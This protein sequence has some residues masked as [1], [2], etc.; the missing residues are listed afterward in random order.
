MG[1]NDE[2]EL[3]ERP[4]HDVTVRSFFLDR[5]EVTHA[6]YETCVTAGRCEPPNRHMASSTHAGAD[7][8]F[9][10]PLQPVVGVRWDDAK[11]YC[12]YVG[13]RLPREAEFERAIRGDDGRRY[14]W[15]NEAPTPEHTVFGRLLGHGGTTDDVGTHAK[16]RGQY[17]HDDLAGNV[18]EWMEDLYD[19]LAYSRPG[20]NTGTPGSCDEIL[21]TLSTLRKEGRRGFTGSNPIPKT[22][23]RVL[24]GGA[25]NY[26]RE[27]LRSTNRVH[28]PGNYRLVMSG[29]RC[30]KDAH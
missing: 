24:R 25:F 9:S 28:H 29:F 10:R 12:A 3:D 2:G 5:A 27:G 8:D 26:Q 30:A 20:A 22:C 18:W 7:Q 23:E 17:G 15:G 19:P 16:G 1:T 11:A 14:P 4:A 6:A 21:E 13:K